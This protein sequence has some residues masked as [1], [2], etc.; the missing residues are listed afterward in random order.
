MRCIT[1]ISRHIRL[2]FVN[3]VDKAQNILC[4]C[5]VERTA[6]QSVLHLVVHTQVLDKCTRKTCPVFALPLQS[7]DRQKRNIYLY[8]F[9]INSQMT[10]NH[11]T[12]ALTNTGVYQ[13]SEVCCCFFSVCSV[14]ILTEKKAGV[15]ALQTK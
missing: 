4:F 3:M 12:W 1:I 11:F 2:V 9:K 13:F 6:F 7:H 5:T 14:T 15:D 10:F 8:S